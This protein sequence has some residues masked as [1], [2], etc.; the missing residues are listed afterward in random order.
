MRREPEIRN[1]ESASYEDWVRTAAQDLENRAAG[2]DGLPAV[3]VMISPQFAT[4]IAMLLRN[5][6]EDMESHRG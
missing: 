1:V 5:H 4:W 2:I 3:S 6:A